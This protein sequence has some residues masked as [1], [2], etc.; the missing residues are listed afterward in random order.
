MLP[1]Y[2]LIFPTARTTAVTRDCLQMPC[3]LPPFWHSPTESLGEQVADFCLPS[4]N[5]WRPRCTWPSTPGKRVNASLRLGETKRHH[6][7]FAIELDRQLSVLGV[8]T[9]VGAV[10]PLQYFDPHPRLAL[11]DDPQPRG[12]NA[13]KIDDGSFAAVLSI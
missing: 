1:P 7:K 6:W 13:G 2:W 12:C 3:K 11:A 8:L 5:C 4:S 9:R 10:A